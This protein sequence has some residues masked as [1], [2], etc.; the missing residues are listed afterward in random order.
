M[1]QIEQDVGGNSDG[2][3]EIE[4]DVGGNSDGTTEINA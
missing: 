1:E 3:T 4:Q 2:T